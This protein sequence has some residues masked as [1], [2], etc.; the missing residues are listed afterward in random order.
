MGQGSTQTYGIQKLVLDSF[1]RDLTL[2]CFTIKFLPDPSCEI[3]E[4]ISSSLKEA[5]RLSSGRLPVPLSRG[6]A[7]ICMLKVGLLTVPYFLLN[8]QFPFDPNQNILHLPNTAQSLL[9]SSQPLLTQG[10]SPSRGDNGTANG[11]HRFCIASFYVIFGLKP[12]KSFML[13]EID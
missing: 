5:L 2:H 7:Y 12:V 9:N 4:Y 10:H 1:G 11:F 6:I 3:W 8:H 13:K